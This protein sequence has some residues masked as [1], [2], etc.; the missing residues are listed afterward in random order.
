[1]QGSWQEIQ[2]YSCFLLKIQNLD[3]SA[4]LIFFGNFL[5]L[6]TWLKLGVINS[7]TNYGCKILSHVADPI[8]QNVKGSM[9]NV[10]IFLRV[11]I[12]YKKPVSN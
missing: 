1:M 3:L 11:H 7:T 6:W 2:R 9:F 4:N 12:R 8:F 5:T 10:G